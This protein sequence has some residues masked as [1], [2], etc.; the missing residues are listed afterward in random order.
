MVNAQILSRYLYLFGHLHR[1][2]GIAPHKPI[3]LLSILDEIERGHITDN[4]I[5]L[6]VELVATFREYWNV[7]P[8]PPGNWLERIWLP[9]RYLIQDGFLEL[10]KDGETLTGKEIGEPHS[11]SD[12]RSRVH[13]A[14]FVPELWQLVQEKTAREALRVHLLQT[15]FNISPG[16]IQPFI[17]ADPLAAQLD[18]LIS[19]AQSQPKPK[20]PKA[21]TDDTFYYVRHALFS[22]VIYAL[23][24]NS[25]AVCGLSVR[26]D[27][28]LV[29]EAAH[30]KTFATYHDDHP[31][32][33]IAFCRNH[34][35]MFDGG[36]FSIA[37]DYTLLVSSKLQNVGAFVE[38]GD[39][40]RLP[41]NENCKPAPESVNWHR[42]NRFLK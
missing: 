31:T 9:F 36:G 34:H 19:E 14:R 28:R 16:Q 27:T 33:G 29:V 23:Y 21:I 15:C 4:Q 39:A 2:K 32:N 3:L 30:I 20:K 42:E 18:K 38:T 6:S 11:V 25:C 8:L 40:L 5:I 17:P 10:V 26:T 41:S 35:W 12:M 37:D 24:D 1:N 13:F 22:G 7:L